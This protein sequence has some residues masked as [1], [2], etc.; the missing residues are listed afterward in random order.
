[1]FVEQHTPQSL[2]GEE[3]DRYLDKGWYRAGNKLFTCHLIFFEN[4]LYAVVWIRLPL[5]GYRFR[6]SLRK[7]KSRVEQHFQVLIRPANLDAE[8]EA[9]FEN[10]KGFFK[11]N[12]HGTL[13]QNLQDNAEYNVF[14]TW[15]IGIYE[16]GKLI[17]FS[18]FDIGRNS[19]ASIKAVYHRDYTQYSLGIYT[20]LRE[21]QF[22]SE[23][24]MDYYYPGYVIPGYI[25]FD[26]KLRIGKPEEI[27]YYDMKS[28]TWQ[29]YTEVSPVASMAAVINQ[30]LFSVSQY[31][32]TANIKYEMVFCPEIDSAIFK[33]W[34]KKFLRS[35]IFINILPEKCHGINFVIYYD[36]FSGLFVFTHAV[37]AEKLKQLSGFG[38]LKSKEEIA[39][40]QGLLVSP[41]IIES[42]S[43]KAILKKAKKIQELAYSVQ[44]C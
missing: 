3:L 11:G 40:V 25:R 10:F 33:N 23:K 17:G 37:P 20:M 35:P 31:L 26:Y 30:K 18:F 38:A 29:P 19:L 43:E 13:R 6:K 39:L 24:G 2:S 32:Y 27:E 5:K 14:N 8:K 16:H 42:P 9:L 28:A 34:D 41:L 1:M 7:L 44:L 12:L 36:I 15:E 4:T 21:I 22:A